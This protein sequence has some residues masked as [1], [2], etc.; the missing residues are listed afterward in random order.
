MRKIIKIICVLICM[1]SIFLFSHDDGGRSSKKSDGVMIAVCSIFMSHD[2][3]IEHK[4]KY[5][6]PY[7]YYVRRLAHF[8]IYFVLGFLLLSTVCEYRSLDP[9]SILIAFLIAFLY[10]CSDEFHQLFVLGRS[11]RVFD[12]L[13]DSF[14]AFCGIYSYRLFYKWRR[15]HE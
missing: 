9:K 1:I 7:V 10:A 13:L 2:Q 12:V 3:C 6:D 4:D 15:K 11:A 5:V 14:G 8:S